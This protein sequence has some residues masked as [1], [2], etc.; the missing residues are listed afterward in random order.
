VSKSRV[1]EETIAVENSNITGSVRAPRMCSVCRS[2][3][4]TARACPER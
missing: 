2:I 4:H 3:E 1:E